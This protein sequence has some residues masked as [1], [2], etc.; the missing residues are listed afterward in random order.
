MKVVKNIGD[1]DIEELEFELPKQYKIKIYRKKV[2]ELA[3]KCIVDNYRM[4]EDA[5]KLQQRIATENLFLVRVEKA[6]EQQSMDAI[7]RL[8]SGDYSKMP[9]V[10]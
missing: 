9:A 2:L 1:V 3:V 10:N 4:H 5:R 7:Q 8:M 6:I